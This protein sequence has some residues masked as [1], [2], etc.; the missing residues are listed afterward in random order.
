[1][2]EQLRRLLSEPYTGDQRSDRVGVR[3]SGVPLTPVP[4]IL[5]EP[6][7]LGAIQVTN[8]GSPIV[9]GPDGPT[10]GGYPKL[11]VVVGSHLDRIAQLRPGDTVRFAL[12]A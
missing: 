3:L 10:L 7:C 6:A 9:L 12:K 2:P 4:E 11:A 5:S 8:D 1:M